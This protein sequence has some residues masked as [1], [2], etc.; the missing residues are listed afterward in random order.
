M[1]DAVNIE[2]D[3]AHASALPNGHGPRADECAPLANGVNGTRP[4]GPVEANGDAEHAEH[5]ANGADGAEPADETAEAPGQRTSLLSLP[6]ELLDVV[7]A[8]VPP[9][10]KLSTV[11]ALSLVLPYSVSRRWRWEHLVLSSPRQFYPL[12]KALARERERRLKGGEEGRAAGRGGDELVRTLCVD[13]WKGDV[14]ML[15][16]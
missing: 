8:H 2:N 9:A 12:Y 6:P 15:N 4:Q 7:L 1:G 16:K 14:D 11:R 5:A 13:C 3:K 10:Q